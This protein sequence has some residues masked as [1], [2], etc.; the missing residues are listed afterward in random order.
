VIPAAR[1]IADVTPLGVLHDL[2]KILAGVAVLLGTAGFYG[3]AT[4]IATPFVLA[5]IPIAATRAVWVAWRSR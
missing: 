3:T 5:A 2:G 4:A 1:L